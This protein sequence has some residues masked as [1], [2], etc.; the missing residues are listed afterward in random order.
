MT[1]HPVLVDIDLATLLNLF[2]LPK[3][4]LD[5]PEITATQAPAPPACRRLRVVIVGGSFME[6]VGAALSRLPCAPQVVQ[7]FYWEVNRFTWKNGIVTLQPIDPAMR[8]ADLRDA[9]VL[10]YE[11]NEAILG[12]SNH[13]RALYQWLAAQRKKPLF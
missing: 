12:H 5:V 1:T 8:D 10:L 6:P 4:Y 7:Y 9:D 2:T 3:E 11:E 13:G